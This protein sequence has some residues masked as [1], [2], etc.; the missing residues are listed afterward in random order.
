M[1]VMSPFCDR[2]VFV[3]FLSYF[4]CDTVLI[5]KI[6]QHLAKLWIINYW[7]CVYFVY[8]GIDA[9]EGIDVL[10]NF[11]I[12]LVLCYSILA[13]VIIIIQL[14]STKGCTKKQ[15]Y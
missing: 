7:R 9:Q 13:T 5:M 14:V 10:K 4:S 12:V 6:M 11:G 3:L 2:K 15:I 8:I 1:R